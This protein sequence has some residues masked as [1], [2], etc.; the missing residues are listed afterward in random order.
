MHERYYDNMGASDIPDYRDMRW[1]FIS[2]YR[3]WG[4][5]V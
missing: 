3:M 4:T 2:Y 1:E 5:E